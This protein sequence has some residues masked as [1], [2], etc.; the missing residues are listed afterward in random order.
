MDGLVDAWA[1][2]IQTAAQGCEPNKTRLLFSA[3]GLPEKIVRE[4]DPYPQ[5][6]LATVQEII[7][8]LGPEFSDW[9]LCY[10]SR[11]GPVKWIGPS[12][13]SEIR[14]AAQEAK[15]IIIAPIAFVCDHSETLYELDMLAREKAA[16]WGAASFAVARPP[17]T[18][19]EFINDLASQIEAL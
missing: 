5:E 11:V 6:C 15:Q 18:A 14:R 17:G 10:Q 19:G 8:R 4:G 16:L 2:S 13:E 9:R 7:K 1:G 3:H 12:T